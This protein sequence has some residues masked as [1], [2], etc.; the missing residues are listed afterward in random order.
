MFWMWAISQPYGTLSSQWLQSQFASI[1]LKQTS[2]RCKGVCWWWC[3]WCLQTPKRYTLILA[4][5]PRKGLQTPHIKH[6]LPELL[7][8]CQIFFPQQK[9]AENM[10]K[11]IFA[12]ENKKRKVTSSRGCHRNEKKNSH[13]STAVS[14][15]SKWILSPTVQSYV[16]PCDHEKKMYVDY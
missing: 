10:E 11:I 6:T 1:C 12:R 15:H 3:R 4:K 16:A 13:N 5:R 7:L 8:P 2:I 9:W 14:R